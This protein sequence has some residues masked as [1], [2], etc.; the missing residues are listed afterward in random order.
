MN[1]SK[2]KFNTLIVMGSKD[3][4]SELIDLFK[5][6]MFALK[7]RFNFYFQEKYITFSD[8]GGRRFDSNRKE[9]Y[10][11]LEE[12]IELVGKNKIPLIRD[13]S[14]VYDISQEYKTLMFMSR[15]MTAK[16]R[17][18][19]LFDYIKGLIYDKRFEFTA[20]D[21]FQRRKI[22][23]FPMDDI[24]PKGLI[25]EDS[26]VTM[27]DFRDFARIT[28]KNSRLEHQFL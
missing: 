3:N 25:D 16:I 17:T 28:N 11:K 23:M 26:N 13:Y 24:F 15:R 5:S 2:E 10:D 21:K 7:D 19:Y 27:T 9:V 1:I 4:N 22:F 12:E 6:D 18:K 14:F 8:I 20:T